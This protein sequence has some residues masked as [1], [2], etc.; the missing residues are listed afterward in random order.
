MGTAPKRPLSWFQVCNQLGQSGRIVLRLTQYG[1]LGGAGTYGVDGP[2]KR[3]AGDV[4]RLNAYIPVQ[5]V[6]R[7]EEEALLLHDEILA[8]DADAEVG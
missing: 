7:G 5:L 3:V 2:Q 8:A 4:A 1:I 6:G